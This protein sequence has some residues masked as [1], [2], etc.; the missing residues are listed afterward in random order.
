M[1]AT[2]KKVIFL[3]VIVM[4]GLGISSAMFYTGLVDGTGKNSTINT[5]F[6]ANYGIHDIVTTGGSELEGLPSTTVAFKI[7]GTDTIAPALDFTSRFL[8][9]ETDAESAS[10]LLNLKISS[11]NEATNSFNLEFYA[12]SPADYLDGTFNKTVK[13][14]NNLVEGDEFSNVTVISKP[15]YDGTR[16]LD[17]T[18]SLNIID[19]KSEKMRIGWGTLLAAVESFPLNG[20]RYNL[21]LVAEGDIKSSATGFYYDEASFNNLGLVDPRVWTTLE[22]YTDNEFKSLGISDVKYVMAQGVNSNDSAFRITLA[23]DQPDATTV[24]A[25]VKNFTSQAYANPNVL[26]PWMNVTTLKYETAAETVHIEYP[27]NMIW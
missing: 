2:L 11:D 23:G 21:S 22:A 8:A 15:T 20:G 12:N 19:S 18:V 26:L 13:A 6:G 10:G 9:E 14:L 24:A 17:V 4:L 1:N 3:T 7:A 16:T 25:T 5:N 27:T